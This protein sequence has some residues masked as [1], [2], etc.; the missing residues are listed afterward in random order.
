MGCPHKRRQ[1]MRSCHRFRRCAGAVERIAEYRKIKQASPP[2][3]WVSGS[4]R[5]KT[6]AVVPKMRATIEFVSRYVRQHVQQL[7]L[8]PPESYAVHAHLIPS[9]CLERVAATRSTREGTPLRALAERLRTPLCAPG[10]A[11]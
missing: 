4:S 9:Y 8:T 3:L 2:A 1:R 10:G 5:A 7:D 11:A 6:Y